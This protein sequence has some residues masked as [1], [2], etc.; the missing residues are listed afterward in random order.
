MT[1][2]E[3]SIP[4]REKITEYQGESKCVGEAQF[5]LRIKRFQDIAHSHRGNNASLDSLKTQRR[6]AISEDKETPGKGLFQQVPR[7]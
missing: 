3:E 6:R 1:F 7:D 5:F 2:R 4:V